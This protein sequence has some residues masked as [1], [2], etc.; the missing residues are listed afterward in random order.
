MSTTVLLLR[1]AHSLS[2]LNTYKLSKLVC[3]IPTFAAITLLTLL[4]IVKE[5]LVAMV[6]K[7][8]TQ[9][10]MP[11]GA[12]LAMTMSKGIVVNIPIISTINSSP[13]LWKKNKKKK[14]K[15]KRKNKKN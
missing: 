3:V 12:S 9:A 15:E 11:L 14:K 13:K 6:R 10:S 7:E 5:I 1:D 8:Y 2:L 4:P